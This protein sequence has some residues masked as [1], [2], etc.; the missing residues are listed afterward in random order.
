MLVSLLIFIDNN[1]VISV[2]TFIINNIFISGE[3][4][5]D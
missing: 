4:I 5:A 2:E 1:F 3:N